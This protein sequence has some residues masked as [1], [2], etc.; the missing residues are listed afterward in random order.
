M[1]DLSQHDADYL[2]ICKYYH[3]VY[4]TPLVQEDKSKWQEVNI[5]PIDGYYNTV[6][7]IYNWK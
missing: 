7:V 1:I 4:N 5:W 6:F 2:S 3:A